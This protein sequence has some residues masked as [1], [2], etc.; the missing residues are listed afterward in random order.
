M[1]FDTVSSEY[2]INRRLEK[3]NSKMQM[4][5][6]SR[7]KIQFLFERSYGRRD[8]VRVLLGNIISQAS[9]QQFQMIL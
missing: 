6:S 4:I 5:Y 7:I 3:V 9:H 8:H 2:L 1:R